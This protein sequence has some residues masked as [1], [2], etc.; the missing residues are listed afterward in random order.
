MPVVRNTLALSDLVSQEVVPETFSGVGSTIDDLLGKLRYRNLLVEHSPD[1]VTAFYGLTI[2]TREL[3]VDLLGSGLKLIFFPAADANAP[4]SEFDVSFEYRWAILRYVPEFQTLS[5]AGT[6]RAFFDIFLELVDISEDDF[7][8]GIVEAFISDP[9]PYQALVD[10]LKTW[11]NGSATPLSNLTLLNQPVGYSEIEYV[12]QQ[13]TAANVDVFQ[14]TFD[15]VVDDLNDIDGSI[16]RIVSLFEGWLGDISRDDFEKLLLPQFALAL[17]QVAMAIEVPRNV[18]IPLGA[19]DVPSTDETEHSRLTFTAG[20][21]GYD[22]ETG[23]AIDIDTNIVASLT[24]S[25]IPCIGVTLDFDDIKIDLSRTTNIAEADAD[26]RPADFMGVF[27]GNAVIGLPA[28]WF[29]KHV[30]AGSPPETLAIVGRHLLIGTGGLSG[31]IGLEVID[32]ITGKPKTVKTEHQG[33]EEL[34]FVLGK[35]PDPGSTDPRKGF[36]VGFSSFD[37]TFRQNTLLECKI[38]GS[39][40]VPKFDPPDPIAVALDIHN[41]GD[42]ELTASVAPAHKFRIPGVFN[43]LASSL[44]VGKD[45]KRVYLR[46]C[47]DLDF[48]ENGILATLI[49]KPIHIEKLLIYSDGSMELEGGTIP[50]PESCSLKVGP[51]TIAIT[52][53]HIGAHER[54]HGGV[55]R[56]YRYFGFDGGVSVNPGGVDA[57]GDGIKFY[58]T[59]DG[60]S[61]FHSYLAIDGIGIALVIPGS[62]SEESAALILKG[63]LSLKDPVYQGSISFTLPKAKIHGGGSMKYDTSYPAWIVDVNLELPKPF[64]LGSTSL[65]IYG[66]RGLFGLR[67]VAAKE[68]I[69]APTPGAPLPEDAS[70]GDYYR[71]KQ[72]IKG[73]TYKKFI[74]PAKTG[75]SKNPFSVGVGVGL[76]TQ[77]DGGKIFSSQLFLLVSLPNLIMLEGRADILSKHR[78]AVEDDPPYYAYLALSPE[79]IELGAGVNYLIPKTTGAILNL[80]AVMQAAFYFHNASAWYV[81]FGTKDKPITARIVSMFDGYA[82]L[83]LSASGIETGAGVHFDF[84]K[85]YGPV[86]V[87]AHAYLDMWAYIAFER[88]QAGGGIALGGY[89]DIKVFK[90]GFHI[91]LAATLTVELP[92]PFYIAGSVEICISVNLKVK[93]FEQCCTLEFKWDKDQSFDKS[94]VPVLPAPGETSAAVA[95]HMVSGSTYPVVYSLSDS[96]SQP[97]LVPLDCFID[98]KFAKPVTP[99]TA[100]AALI[101]GY[102]S[103]PVGSGERMTPQYGSRVVEHTYSLDAV[104]IHIKDSGGAWHPYHPYTAL[105]PDSLLDNTILTQLGTMPLGVWQKQDQGYCQIRFLAVTP[106]SWMSDMG[107]YVPEEMGI[108]AKSTYCV[109]RER[110]ETCLQWTMPAHYASDTDY[111]LGN[112]LFRVDGD[113][114]EALSLSRPGL[115]PIS[116][117]IGPSG[118]A[119]F[120]FLEPTVR[121]RLMLFTTAPS[122]AVHWQRRKPPVFG[123]GPDTATVWP[124]AAPEFEDVGA[125]LVVQR[126][127]L[128]NP[129]LYDNPTQPIERIV[130][131]TPVPDTKTIADLEEQIARTREDWIRASPA[132]RRSDEAKLARLRK[133]LQAEHDKT[134]VMDRDTAAHDFGKEIAAL[135][136]QLAQIQKQ[137]DAKQSTYKKS[138]VVPFAGPVPPA[139]VTPVPPAPVAP[140]PPASAAPGAAAGRRPAV[141]TAPLARDAATTTSVA[142]KGAAPAQATTDLPGQTGRVSAV[143]RLIDASKNLL[144]PPMSVDDCRKLA[145]EISALQEQARAL[146]GRIDALQKKAAEAAAALKLPPGWECGTFVHEICWM[147]AADYAYNQSIP[148]IAA[149]EADFSAMRAACEGVISPIWQPRETYRITLTL[150]DKVSLPGGPLVSND[151]QLYYIHFKT[152]GPIGYFTALPTSDISVPSSSGGDDRTEAPEVAL[153]FYID[154]GKSTPDPAGKLLYAKPIYCRDVVLRLFFN[155]P[156]AYHFFADWPDTGAGPRHYALELA[157]K[158][159]AEAAA[160]PMTLPLPPDYEAPFVTAPLLG[161]QSWSVDPAPGIAEEIKV[162]RN[163]QNPLAGGGEHATACLSIGGNPITPLSKS[164]KVEMGDLEPDKLY[165]AVILNRDLDQ[166]LVAEVG[167]YPFQ[168]SH[169]AD[170]AAHIASLR[171]KDDAQN[172]RLAV[173]A[174]DHVLAPAG[175]EATVLAAALATVLR[176]PTTDTLVYADFFDRLIY[177]RLK[178][179][180]PPSA[181]SLEINFMTNSAT[182][183]TYGLWV[184]SPEPLFDPRLPESEIN[185]LLLLKEA[186]AVRADASVLFSKD[187]CQAFIMVL[188]GSLPTQNVK[189]SFTNKTWDGHAYIQQTVDSEAFNKP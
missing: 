113:I 185:G 182:G 111:N 147:S 124:W 60:L 130:L 165:T 173:F 158:D 35:Q 157:V 144:N 128:A 115:S 168:T 7:L 47:G 148:G 82:Y 41:D 145:A 122:I 57:R 131:V 25:I 146:A 135:Q 84:D 129:V 69:V 3:A 88:F 33:P 177:S 63:Y 107:G 21:L 17:Q 178:L 85:S 64:P 8:E 55:L 161:A 119:S 74:T 77:T 28:K 54:E 44:S 14:A 155:Y 137:I 67:Y 164:L 73:V 96:E 167:R 32:A 110:E 87:A 68:A 100:I 26:G 52:A 45:D 80:N 123:S 101:G 4:E 1:N 104:A 91:E 10:K 181:I 66:F 53:L 31:E 19:N 20:G 103:P 93:K 114:M 56:K 156:H 72:D 126:A 76:C 172:E 86:H 40:T 152:G 175:N 136:S 90:F 138:C 30:P 27:V 149:I 118:S 140:V 184:I 102:T 169:Y 142:V 78:V 51:A 50:L 108:T 71:A 105:A 134:C 62:A 36:K 13:I 125:P 187:R 83:M 160:V 120:R 23:F 65:G 6:G 179:P 89:V 95:V 34:E 75:G 12:I 132:Q 43:F 139:P 16:D 106:F 154:M 174:I 141:A 22:S 188:A 58:Y 127:A 79:S 15:A 42:F 162:I 92:H 24:K 151:P 39:L 49:K 166:T 46:T 37:M 2:V 94:A 112:V 171:L 183:W 59:V 150:S 186:D 99:S 116:L 180:P 121:C 170:F 70:W 189:L 97:P 18:L 29:A 38:K 98:V 81:H 11:S 117:G 48:S 163:F 9:A 109:A 176:T 153:K 159:P 143:A 5:F 61:P 133:Q